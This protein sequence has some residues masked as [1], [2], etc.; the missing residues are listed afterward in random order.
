VGWAFTNLKSFYIV[1]Y[2]L[3]ADDDDATGVK[4]KQ[5]KIDENDYD[6]PDD[7]EELHD[8]NGKLI[9]LFIPKTI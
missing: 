6:D 1:I 2:I 3:K 5:R 8:A 7:V 4:L 9:L